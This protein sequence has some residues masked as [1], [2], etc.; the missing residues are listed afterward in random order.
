M[1]NLGQAQGYPWLQR[2]GRPILPSFKERL[3]EI[4]MGYSTAKGSPYWSTDAAYVM[5]EKQVESI[6]NAM[7]NV[8]GMIL[9]LIGS[10]VTAGD[11]HLFSLR[12]EMA[13]AV[14]ASWRGGERALLGRFD[15]SFASDG[16]PKV[17]EYNADTPTGLFEAAIVQWEWY[18]GQAEANRPLF[19]N[20]SQFNT[21][22]RS[23]IERWKHLDI[24][25]RVDFTSTVIP[26]VGG[27]LAET[28]DELLVSQYLKDTAETAGLKT[29]EVRLTD[30]GWDSSERFFTDASDRKIKNLS[31]IYPWEWLEIDDYGECIP[32]AKTRFIEPA[33]KRLIADKRLLAL[34][35]DRHKGHP[36]LLQTSLL[37]GD[38]FGPAVSK[39]VMGR[40][41]ANIT[42]P[43]QPVTPGIYGS[44]IKIFQEFCP[45]PKFSS[46][47]GDVFV[48]LGAWMVGDETCGVGV[49]EDDGVVT[50]SSDSFAPH[51]FFC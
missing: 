47:R 50:G 12:R 7:A 10:I 36:N 39:P 24:K 11:Y 49:R 27:S 35:W 13:Q 20:T 19:A 31:K 43:G 38:M 45:I 9:D 26:G 6:E 42:I 15:L 41:G 37:P 8:H 22:N 32:V 34:L 2:V 30:V 18:E 25:G 14:D 16:T 48:T 1:A 3:S 21:I 5:T 33:W 28:P 17:L 4:N 44:Q 29:G 51:Y 46:E 23:L 40:A